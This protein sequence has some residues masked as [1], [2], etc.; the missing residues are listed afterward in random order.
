MVYTFLVSVSKVKIHLLPYVFTDRVLDEMSNSPTND[1]TIETR[2][3][4]AVKVGSCN[5]KR[6]IVIVFF[7]QFDN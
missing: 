5:F 7:D 3:M 6:I 2:K 1:T 4:L